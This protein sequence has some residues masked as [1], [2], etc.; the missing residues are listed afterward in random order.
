MHAIKSINEGG[1][2]YMHRQHFCPDC[3]QL[4]ELGC[5]EKV[6][7][8]NSPE[9][10]DYD[11]SMPGCRGSY[12]GDVLFRIGCFYCTNCEKPFRAKQIKAFEKAQKRAA[13]GS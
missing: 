11:F 13:K 6:V 1:L 9:A 10:K 7:N 8:S 3:G 2:I 12:V 5:I 4:L